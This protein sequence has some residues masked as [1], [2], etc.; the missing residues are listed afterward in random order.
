VRKFDQLRKLIGRARIELVPGR[1]GVKGVRVA[2]GAPEEPIAVRATDLVQAQF[3]ELPGI[4]QL[5][6]GVTHA[7]PW[8]LGDS[9]TADNGMATWAPNPVDIGGSVLTA[10]AAGP[11]TA[12]AEAWHRGFDDDPAL[13]AMRK[14]FTAANT[15]PAGFQQA[16]PA[17]VAAR[18]TIAHSPNPRL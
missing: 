9:V 7:M 16:W 14:R 8:R 1:K 6:S 4:Y 10:L 17:R 3:S 13:A 18:P 15:L 12:A 5:L 11:R 2:P